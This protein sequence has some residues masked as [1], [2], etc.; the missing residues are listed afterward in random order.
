[1]GKE[2]DT[3]VVQLNGDVK[4]VKTVACRGDRGSGWV[5]LLNV[6]LTLQYCSINQ[7]DSLQG[8]TNSITLFLG[9]FASHLEML[10]KAILDI[11]HL[12]G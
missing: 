8:E 7:A 4:I 3:N 12:F 5:I 10:K 1:M 6:V 2:K 11:L 9:N